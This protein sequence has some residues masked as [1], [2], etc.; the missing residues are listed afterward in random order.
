MDG[1]QSFLYE[2]H[3]LNSVVVKKINKKESIILE[4]DVGNASEWIGKDRSSIYSNYIA[5]LHGIF[6]N[7]FYK[8]ALNVKIKKRTLDLGNRKS[9]FA[10]LFCFVGWITMQQLPSCL[11]S[12][13]SGTGTHFK[14]F[15]TIFSAFPKALLVIT[16]LIV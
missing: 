6:K 15:S 10:V 2:Y 5:C 14:I 13:Y 3:W 8:V 4:R 16:F 9:N 12:S 7:Y 11:S 1:P